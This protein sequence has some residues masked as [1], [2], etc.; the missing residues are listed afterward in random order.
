MIYVLYDYLPNIQH[1]SQVFSVVAEEIDIMK[2][3]RENVKDVFVTGRPPIKLK[4]TFQNNTHN[5][6][7]E[8]YLFTNKQVL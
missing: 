8:N 3:K 4:I 2:D 7:T 1:C 6:I 5:T